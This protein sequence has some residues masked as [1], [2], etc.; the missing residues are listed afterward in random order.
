MKSLGYNIKN[1]KYQDVLTILEVDI[2]G[3]VPSQ[4]LKEFIEL[5]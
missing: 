3:G 1:V 5:I 2:Y 4:N